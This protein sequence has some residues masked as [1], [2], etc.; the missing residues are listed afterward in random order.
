MSAVNKL[1]DVP[2]TGRG[3]CLG[4][5]RWWRELKVAN[6]PPSHMELTKQHQKKDGFVPYWT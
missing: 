3:K 6:K 2:T 1:L 4:R 5:G